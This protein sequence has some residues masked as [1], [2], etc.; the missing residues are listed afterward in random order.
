MSTE[1]KSV[2]I[3]AILRWVFLGLMPLLLLLGSFSRSSY[4]GLA[5]VLLTI[6]SFIT[7]LIMHMTVRFHRR[8]KQA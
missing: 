7:F 4:G 5:S 6:A 2:K 8:P 3:L 1:P